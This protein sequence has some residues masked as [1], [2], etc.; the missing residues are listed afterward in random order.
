MIRV[1]STLLQLPAPRAVIFDM[2]GVLCDSEHFMAEAACRMFAELHHITPAP[3]DF[4]PFSGM[5]EDRYLGGVAT[6]YGVTLSMPRDK[7]RAYEIYLDTVKGR[8]EPL[9]G[10][11]PFIAGCRRLGL[12]LAV[13]SSADWMK[14]EGNLREIQLPPDSFDVC[15]TGNDVTRKKPH[16]EIFL[17]AATRLGIPSSDCLVIEDAPNGVRAAIAAGCSCLGLTTSFPP[18]TLIQ[19]GAT[20][21]A[22][23]LAQV[24]LNGMVSDRN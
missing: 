23:D 20:W 1:M 3:K 15:L 21:I 11:R 8:L 17:T 10:C 22:P 14:V 18:D 19:A 12:R 6:Q 2:D 24:T 13:A 9:P 16:P 4:A 7:V 5:G